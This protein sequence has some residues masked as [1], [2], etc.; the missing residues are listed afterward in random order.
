M[1]KAMNKID[2]TLLGIVLIITAAAAFYFDSESRTNADKTDSQPVL[3]SVNAPARPRKEPPHNEQLKNS[4]PVSSARMPAFYQTPPESG[5]IPA[6]L[7]P[8]RF[9][10][11]VRNA[12]RAAREIPRTIAQLPCFCHCD[13]STGHKSLH[14][15]FEDEHGS[16]C[17]ICID[18][19][20]TAYRLEKEEKLS[21]A[22]IRER[23]V[24]QYAR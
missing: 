15:C 16:R 24:A 5:L 8:E 9:T 12:Y 14:S 20:L 13:K 4:A 2:K 10:G 21:P 17:A 23:I 3:M 6:V 11:R 7:D 19:A 22:E 1:L 18:E